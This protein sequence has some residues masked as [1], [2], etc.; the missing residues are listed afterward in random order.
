MSTAVDN[1]QSPNVSRANST[2]GVILGGRSNWEN[3][4]RAPFTFRHSLEN[5]PLFEISKL[6]K[7]A[8]AAIEKRGPRKVYIPNDEELNKLPWKK[9]LPE[10]LRRIEGGSLWLKLSGL[11]ELDPDY[12]DLLQTFLLEIEELSGSPLRRTASWAGLTVF[13]ASP[14][15]VT[16]YHFDHDT[17]FLF[18]IKGEKDVHVFDRSVVTEEEIEYFYTGEAMAGKYRDGMI[19]KS[20]AFHLTPGI[21]VHHPPLAPHLVKNG[22]NVSISLSMFYADRSLDER[23]KIYQA[24]YCLRRLGLKPQPPGQS[25]FRD[26]LKNTAIGAFSK[27]NPKSQDELLFSGIKRVLSP[28]RGANWIVRRALSGSNANDAHSLPPAV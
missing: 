16:P 13:I 17:N 28:Q 11:Q 24:N 21:A 2:S 10:A 25:I 8:E 26:R 15:V 9:R 1:A 23:A 19:N 7:V 4:N 5:H 22:A 20:E 14:N 18:Q 12:E 3:L 27:W 6:V